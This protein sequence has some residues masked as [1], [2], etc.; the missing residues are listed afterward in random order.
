MV[1]YTKIILKSIIDAI[2][3]GKGAIKG[4]AALVVAGGAA[5]VI[6]IV[7]ICLAAIVGGKLMGNL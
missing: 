3:A 6:V 7:I 2:K 4:T 5:G 1:R